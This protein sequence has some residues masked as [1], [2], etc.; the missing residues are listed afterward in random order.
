MPLDFEEGAMQRRDVLKGLA[1]S[2]ALC[3]SRMSKNGQQ[4]QNN[5]WSQ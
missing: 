5:P 3:E 2:A 4:R 1:G